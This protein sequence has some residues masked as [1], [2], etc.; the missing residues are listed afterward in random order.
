MADVSTA[1]SGG[2]LPRREQ[3]A[4]AVFWIVA[5]NGLEAATVREVAARAGVS[6]GAVQHHFP[7]KDAMLA[8][9]FRHIVHRTRQRLGALAR[10]G[11]ATDDLAAIL[12]ELLPLDESRRAEAR[13]HVAFAARA[14]TSRALQE[15]QRP[16]LLEIRSEIAE[17]L[18]EGGEVQAAL[19]LAL[20]DGLALHEVSAPG[21]MPAEALETVLGTAVAAAVEP[22]CGSPGAAHATLVDGARPGAALVVTA[23]VTTSPCGAPRPAAPTTSRA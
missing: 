15:I 7:T 1:N 12:W 18:G 19:L 17:R 2:R 5:E 6:I 23:D 10:N 4:E 16:M 21:G 22:R 9:A 20:V 3:L 14:G 8:A 11:V 13:V